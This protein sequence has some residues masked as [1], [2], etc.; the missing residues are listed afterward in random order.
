MIINRPGFPP[1]DVLTHLKV[2]VD[3]MC[4]DLAQTAQASLQAYTPNRWKGFL[5]RAVSVLERIPDGYGVGGPVGPGEP[6]PE[7]TS[8]PRGT[9]QAFLDEHKK[10][11]PEWLATKSFPKHLAWWILPK[12]AKEKL[13]EERISGK[14]G[15]TPPNAPYWLIA[16]YG[17]KGGISSVDTGVPA[18]E[19]IKKSRVEVAARE[20][21]LRAALR[22]TP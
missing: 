6:L 1:E 11:H 8:A 7:P 10:E 16:E 15:G 19:F 21:Q 9:I 20:A 22:I 18:L 12:E 3:S 13:K 17:S 2:D 4:L 5:Y 14:F